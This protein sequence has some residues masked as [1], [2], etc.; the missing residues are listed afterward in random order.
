MYC[1][2]AF[3][4]NSPVILYMNM[5]ATSAVALQSVL[6]I[7]AVSMKLSSIGTAYISILLVLL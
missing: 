5:I 1:L 7:A 6:D 3:A 4:H 2:F